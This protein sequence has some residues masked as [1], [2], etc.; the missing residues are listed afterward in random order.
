[1]QIPSGVHIKRIASI[2]RYKKCHQ[3][4]Y[5]SEAPTIYYNERLHQLPTLKYRRLRGDMIVF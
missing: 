1:M 5:I 4:S 3:V 2:E